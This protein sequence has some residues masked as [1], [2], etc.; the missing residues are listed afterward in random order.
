MSAKPR[1]DS[2]LKNLPEERQ[3]AIA[4]WCREPKTEECPGGLQHAREML[5]SDG[6]KVSLR[7]VSEFFAWYRMRSTLRGIDAK[8][9]NYEEL[10]KKEC[11][12]ATLEQIAK[13]GQSIFTMEA[14]TYGDVKTFIE[15]E[16]L[17]LAQATAA[18]KGRQKEHDL[19]L[20]GQRLKVMQSKLQFE[21]GKHLDQTSEKLLSGAMRAKA[22]EINASDISQAEKIA[23]MRKEAFADV[24][25]YLAQGKLDLPE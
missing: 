16:S 7:A 15:L 1:S 24:D 17:R 4:E 25:A 18:T 10:F 8:A 22:D 5:A 9:A 12:E 20:S 6:L 14:S 13:I 19:K 2:I 11:P 23:A 21:I 3:D